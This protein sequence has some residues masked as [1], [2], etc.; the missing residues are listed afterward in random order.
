MKHI[1]FKISYDGSAFKGFQK[2]HGIT[3]VQGEIENALKPIVGDVEISAVSR[4]D[5]GVHA[6]SQIFSFSYDT[7]IPHGRLAEVLTNA[8]STRK[9]DYRKQA[10]IAIEGWTELG[11]AMNP[12]YFVKGK[13]YIYVFKKN[14]GSDIFARNY[15]LLTNGD[16]NV[17][18]MKEEAKAF[19]G[20]HDFSA[21]RTQDGRSPIRKV[22]SANVISCEELNDGIHEPLTDEYGRISDIIALKKRLLPRLN[23]SNLQGYVFFAVTGEGFLY[24]M[25][26]I[27][28][29][30]LLEVG[31]NKFDKPVCDVLK[32]KNRQMAGIT[33]PPQGLYLDEVFMNAEFPAFNVID[34]EKHNDG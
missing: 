22:F 19:V 8:F 26:R 12:R 18:R 20:E 13:R 6:F 32:S 4:T 1:A 23:L 30:T 28:A 27:M 17:G 33:A 10:A 34:L 31:K 29:G 2:N 25:V 3:S 11:R 24:N 7:N 16:L 14:A 5:A 21:F 9:S 15:M